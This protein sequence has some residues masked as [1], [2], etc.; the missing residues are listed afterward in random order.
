MTVTR[1]VIFTVLTLAVAGILYVIQI[2][3]RRM[4]QPLLRCILWVLKALLM[5]WLAYVL[6]ALASPFLWRFD[7]ALTALY[8][9]LLGDLTAELIYVLIRRKKVL[10]ILIC[11]CTLV[12]LG[13]SM[14]NM[15]TIRPVYHTYQSEK[16]EAPCRIVFL[17]DLHYGSSQTAGTVSA[18][19]SKITEEQP[20]YLILGGD[21]TDEHTTNE[22]MHSIFRE[23]SELGIPTYYIYGN[24]DR[25]DRASYLDGPAFSEAELQE[26]IEDCGIT[27]LY[28][29]SVSLRDDLLLYGSEDPSRPEQFRSP[30]T[31]SAFPEEPFTVY[32]VHTPPQPGEAIPDTDLVLS[33]HTHAGQFFPVRLM[34]TVA[35]MHCVW[36]YAFDDTTL[37]VSPGIAGWYLPVRNE[38]IC[39]YEVIDLLPE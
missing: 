34:Y 20:D 17:S 36:E 15:S 31:L 35:G 9:A 3:V 14:W 8:L 37:L 6:I 11:V 33:G 27:I 24:H 5:M 30:D 7:Y 21:I 16:L 25:Q 4:K 10:P 2:P 29:E 39:S 38:S 23:I 28:N 1:F 12:H 13:Y 19:L 26:T 18:A 22:E 32:L